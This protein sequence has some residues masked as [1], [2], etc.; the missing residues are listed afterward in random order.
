MG[1][2]TW[3]VLDTCIHYVCYVDVPRGEGEKFDHGA[4]LA[5]IKQ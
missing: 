4:R 1:I 3:P 2:D 5:G